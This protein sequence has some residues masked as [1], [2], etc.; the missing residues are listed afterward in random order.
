MPSVLPLWKPDSYLFILL[1]G[2]IIIHQGWSLSHSQRIPFAQKS[3]SSITQRTTTTTT[4]GVEIQDIR[5]Q[6]AKEKNAVVFIDL[7]NVR[8][9]DQFQ[10]CHLQF[11]EQITTW[12]QFQGLQN[13][14]SLIVDHGTIPCGYYLSKRTLSVIFAG[15]RLKADDVIVRDVSAL[16]SHA[17]IVT[18][19]NELMSRCRIAMNSIEGG[20]YEVQFL[21]PTKVLQDFNVIQRIQQS[22]SSSTAITTT[23]TNHTQSNIAI[24]DT[25][26][27]TLDQEIQIRGGL[28]ETENLIKK[29]IHINSPK[30]RRKLE[31]RARML[32]ER[33]AQQS[34]SG[35]GIDQLTS[36]D[37]TISEYDR[38]FQNAVLE[39]WVTLRKT[40]TR[41][42]MT[43][44]RIML[45]E[46][47]RRTLESEIEL[48]RDISKV[49]VTHIQ[50]DKRI[51]LEQHATTTTTDIPC[52]IHDVDVNPALHHV[53]HVNTLMGIR[54]PSLSSNTS[55]RMGLS[56]SSSSSIASPNESTHTSKTSL[57]LVVISDTHGYEESLTPNG[58][59]LPEGDILL[60]LGDFAIDGSVRKK[61]EALRRF[62]DWLSTQNHRIKVVLR[63]N[64]DPFSVD[65]TSSN[66][67]YYAGPK[68]I[69]IDGQ[70][71]LTVV[72][73]TSARVL[74]GSWRKLP[75]Q[76]D[77]LA[78][79]VPPYNIL[80]RCQSGQHAGCN[81]LRSKVERMIAGAPR[82]WL[83]GHIHE[84]R[85]SMNMKF[86]ISSRD[87]LIINASNANSGRANRIVHGP[88]VVDLDIH[89]NVNI[90]HVDDVVETLQVIQ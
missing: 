72:P 83:C 78:S 1:A 33:L 80:D 15:P 86:G 57:R 24:S 10:T 31:K 81:A 3:H 16:Q 90:V 9:K 49:I 66:A 85:G 35:L 36:V 28:Y 52:C 42:E 50:E 18:A 53:Q 61:R 29:K 23:R 43:G 60:H 79:H 58:K 69:T 54:L 87:T 38:Q 30:S 89:G 48:Y 74:S 75:L 25:L 5:I 51:S 62:D 6:W 41:K 19:D 84:G 73:Y 64:H 63:G 4:S 71:V 21:H 26:L 44:D 8:G 40:A 76:Y 77:I 20:K 39:Q 17:L 32:C 14:V 55:H 22:V 68:S 56:S 70:F 67:Q 11:L 27:Q 47:F 13:K 46:H 59:P 12:T 34:G 88:T 37:G 82:L 45:A 7:E 2:F 65:F